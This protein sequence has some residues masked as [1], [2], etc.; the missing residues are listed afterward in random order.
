M[1]TEEADARKSV[2]KTAK[3]GKSGGI[4]VASP[5]EILGTPA[6]KKRRT[7]QVIGEKELQSDRILQRKR[8]NKMLGIFPDQRAISEQ[9]PSVAAGNPTATVSLTTAS[10][11]V[12]GFAF[13]LGNNMTTASC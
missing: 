9:P 5:A 4:Q 2:E 10:S 7:G 3:S 13:N 8:L 12:G 1:E 6:P 11:S